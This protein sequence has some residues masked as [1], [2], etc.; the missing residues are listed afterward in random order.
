MLKIRLQH[1]GRKKVPFY[2][3][4]VAEHAAAVQGK[5]IDRLGFYNPIIKPWTFEV[6]TEKVLEWIKKGAKPSNTVARLLKF[7]GVKD[8]D[9][10]VIE[11]KNRKKKKEEE[12]K[13]EPKVEVSPTEDVKPDKASDGTEEK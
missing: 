6:D 7:A 12:K 3:V 4:V 8:V 10:F 1:T 13:E 11:M 5:V 9:K 2:R